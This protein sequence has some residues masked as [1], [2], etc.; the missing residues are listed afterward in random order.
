VKLYIYDNVAV[1]ALVRLSAMIQ[2]LVAIYGLA[3]NITR[4]FATEKEDL[5]L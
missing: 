4:D 3:L 2:S 5:V 1:C